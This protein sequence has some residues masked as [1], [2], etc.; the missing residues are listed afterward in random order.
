[1]RA[2]F[3]A[4]TTI[5]SSSTKTGSSEIKIQ[6]RLRRR[7]LKNLAVLIKPVES[8]PAQLHQPRLQAFA[9]RLRAQPPSAAAFALALRGSLR[10]AWPSSRAPAAGISWRTGNSALQ[11]R[12]FAQRQNRLRNLVHR[13][14]LYQAV[15][16]DAV[17]FSAARVQQAQVVVD[18]GRRGHRRARIPRRVLL[19]DG[20]CRSQP[21]DLVHVG[22]FDPLKKLARIRRQR[23]DI[24][25]L[26]LGIDG[27]KGQRTLARA[28]HAA[29]HC[30]L[31]V[32][33]LAGNVLQIVCPRAADDD[34]VVR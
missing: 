25:P 16:I 12:P 24:P 22:L 27:V 29:D 2:R 8:R 28:R 33:N 30:Q 4:L 21:I 10:R 15:A 19:L 1:M 26:S 23:L 18:L 32:R 5:R 6:Q 17:H 3:S 14:A 13:V 31:A 7:E 20:N 9:H 11:P 34:R